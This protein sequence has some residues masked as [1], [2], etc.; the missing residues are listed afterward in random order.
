VQLAPIVSP[1]PVRLTGDREPLMTEPATLGAPPAAPVAPP[2]P[3]L[4]AELEALLEETLVPNTSSVEFERSPLTDYLGRMTSR[5]PHVAEVFLTNSRITPASQANSPADEVALHATREWMFSTA[6]RPDEDEV[7]F[8]AAA[9]AR[10]RVPLAQ[11]D[12][13]A[14]P[15]LATLLEDRRALESLYA[16]EVYVVVGCEVFRLAPPTDALWL[17]TR[18]TLQERSGL[19]AAVLGPRG[20]A[21]QERFDL[22]A[23]IAVPWRHMLYQG[24]RGLRRTLADNGRLQERLD[25]AADACGVRAAIEQD[26]VDDIVDGALDLDGVERT[27][28]AL[29][30]IDRGE[31]A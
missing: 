8:A 16:L 28:V 20:P 5:V 12:S 17:V 11:L 6:F 13:P 23:V 30:R 10:V 27:T 9:Q 2:P 29:M 19:A 14:A 1:P 25:L 3:T 15:V 21:P 24:P 31:S 22:L 18:L 4:S 26:Y 7:D